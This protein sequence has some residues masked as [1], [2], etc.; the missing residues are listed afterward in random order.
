MIIQ[1]GEFCRN[2][3]KLPHEASLFLN[4]RDRDETKNSL[5]NF[6][7]LCRPCI[8][9]RNKVDG[10]DDLCVKTKTKEETCLSI[11]R[12]KEPKFKEFVYKT[13]SRGYSISS[14][15]I[16]NSGAEEIGASPVTT[17]HYLDKMVSGSG[18]LTEWNHDGIS[19]VMF[20]EKNN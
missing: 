2:C 13:I 18:E 15:A 1:H 11:N 9:F 7:F 4:R 12:E 6:Q 17:R 5:D 10:H 20:K 14:K 3:G 8:A 16:I 19:M